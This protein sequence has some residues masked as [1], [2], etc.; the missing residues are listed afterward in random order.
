MSVRRE[1]RCL[2]R[3]TRYGSTPLQ[4]FFSTADGARLEDLTLAFPP[5][6][7]GSYTHISQLR[8]WDRRAE[9]LFSYFFCMGSPIQKVFPIQTHHTKIMAPQN[10]E[11]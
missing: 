5:R 1:T 11:G 4:L 2:C 9:Y 3:D 7:L 6:Y 10:A 8:K